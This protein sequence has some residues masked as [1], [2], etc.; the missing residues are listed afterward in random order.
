MP[1]IPGPKTHA[2]HPTLITLGI[3]NLARSREFY[4]ALGFVASA[5]S[6]G[7]V[8]FFATPGVAVSLYPRAALAE[9]AGVDGKGSG[10]SGVTLSHN[11]KEQADVAVEVLEECLE[12]AAK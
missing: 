8:V 12:L 2:P 10:F 6:Q 7:D 4:E 9:D 3:S 1:I 11:V 5:A